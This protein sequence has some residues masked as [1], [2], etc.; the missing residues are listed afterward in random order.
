MSEG[1]EELDNGKARRK[2]ILLCSSD[3]IV[4]DLGK[5]DG[6]THEAQTEDCPIGPRSRKLMPEKVRNSH[7][8][9]EEG[10]ICGTQ[11]S[12]LFSILDKALQHRVYYFSRYIILLMSGAVS[13][14][15]YP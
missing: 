11:Q 7:T 8:N 3:C 1:R 9:Q 13:E 2:S 5:C 15:S 4:D 14:C 10:G 12:F 6:K